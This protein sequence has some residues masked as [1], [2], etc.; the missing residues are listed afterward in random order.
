M[1]L[2]IAPLLTVIIS[3]G[4]TISILPRLIDKMIKA[5]ICGIDVNKIDKP[6]IPEM[7]GIAGVLGFTLGATFMLGLV[8]YFDTIDDYP[9]LVSISVVCIAS[10]IGLLDDVSILGRKEKA[11]FISLAALPIIISQIGEPEIN[12]IF[13]LV[14][15]EAYPLFFWL[16]LVPLGITCCANALNMSAG[17]NGLESGQFTIISFTLLVISF[18]DET[19]LPIVIIYAS[20]FGSSIGLYTFNKYPS[21]IFLG[22]IATLGFGSLIAATV[23]MSGHIIYGVICIIPTFYELFSTVKYSFKGIERRGACMN[24]IITK[25]GK[26]R[27]PQEAND[28][29]L[30]YFLL[31][32]K[33][34]NEK[35]LVTN[36]LS[37]YAFCGLVSILISLI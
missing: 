22:D 15:F 19:S 28:Y 8:K 10:L 21:K 34:M 35:T 32:R 27:V 24:P 7:G 20:I 5:D 13:Y 9:V 3:F 1:I 4:I 6:K 17:Y 12:F 2:D 14:S 26:L 11:W 37:L 36:I 29:T 23:I 31:S 30:A 18:F 33:E 16:I 25:D